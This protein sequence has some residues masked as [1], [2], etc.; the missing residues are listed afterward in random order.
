MWYLSSVELRQVRLDG[1]VLC[2]M[3]GFS[4]AVRDLWS[5][6]PSADSGGGVDTAVK[7][8]DVVGRLTLRSVVTLGRRL[9]LGCARGILTDRE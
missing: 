1:V 3:A 4:V 5:S 9:A 2:W 6:L 7:S 8:R